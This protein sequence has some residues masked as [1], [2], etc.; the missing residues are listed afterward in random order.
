MSYKIEKK[1]IAP[2]TICYASGS[3]SASEIPKLLSELLPRVVA[4]VKEQKGQ[5]IGPPFTRYLSMGE[6][7]EIQAGL[8]LQDP[9]PSGDGV[10]VA[11]LPGGEALVTVHMGP[12]DDLNEAYGAIA[13]HVQANDLTPGA[14]MW[15]YYWTDPQE[16]PDPA[17]WKTEIFQPIQP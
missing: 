17:N 8:P 6:T 10:E 9:I 2:Q 4:H 12:Y 15:E 3:G 16:E 13:K 14:T 5:I 11:K 1:R 7:L